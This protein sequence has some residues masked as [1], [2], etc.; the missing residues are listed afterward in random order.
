MT[1]K[2]KWLSAPYIFWSVIFIIVPL[3]MILY[4]GLTDTTGSFTLDNITAIPGNRWR[5]PQP[6]R[7]VHLRTVH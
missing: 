3:G 4:Y 7:A 5:I 1:S 6:R 2:N